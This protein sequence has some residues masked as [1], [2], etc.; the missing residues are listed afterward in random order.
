M[1]EI[2]YASNIFP[3]LYLDSDGKK[4]GL[5]Q[6]FSEGCYNDSISWQRATLKSECNLIIWKRVLTIAYYLLQL[7]V[8]SHCTAQQ[9]A[10]KNTLPCTPFNTKNAIRFI[11]RWIYNPLTSMEQVMCHV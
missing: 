8:L 10:E 2:Q 1:S 3:D 7:S 4:L 9:R 11:E 6:G 5:H